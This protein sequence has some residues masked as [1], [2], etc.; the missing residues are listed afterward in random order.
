MVISFDGVDVKL[1]R[2]L[3]IENHISPF[4][5]PGAVKEK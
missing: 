3:E 4:M 1:K 5:Y 2:G